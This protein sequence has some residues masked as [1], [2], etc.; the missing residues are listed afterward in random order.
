[1]VSFAGINV[2]SVVHSHDAGWDGTEIVICL[3]QA[4]LRWCVSIK[5]KKNKQVGK[6]ILSYFYWSVSM[7]LILP[8]L[9]KKQSW[10]PSINLARYNMF[11]N[12]G[13]KNHHTSFH[14]I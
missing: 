13:S 10:I 11:P 12:R 8:T 7:F 6:K 1:M 9:Q 5:N 2:T 4:T 14:S 3:E